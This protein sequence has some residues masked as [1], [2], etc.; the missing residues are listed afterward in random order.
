MSE[1]AGTSGP[2]PTSPDQS[3]APTT[4]VGSTSAT[5]TTSTSSAGDSSGG[6]PAWGSVLDIIPPALHDAVKG[7]LSEYDKN[8]N[9]R[10]EK[11]QSDY[12]P[13]KQFAGTDPGRMQEAL[14]IYQNLERDPQ[15]FYNL[16]AENLGIDVSGQGQTEPV[17]SD[18]DEI[19]LSDGDVDITEHPYVKQLAAQVEQLTNLF[20]GQQAQ[21]AQAKSD[22]WLEGR[23][24]NLPEGVDRDFV[25]THTINGINNQNMDPDKSMDAAIEKWNNLVGTIRSQP[26]AADSAPNVL[27]PSGG[28][29]VAPST[30]TMKMGGKEFRAAAAERLAQLNGANN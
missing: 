11:V 30:R 8:A 13:F 27:S 14:N 22:A 1:T 16:L 5:E 2:I 20:N 29:P 24:T 10:I 7:R 9:S 18:I 21:E 28:S 23:I 6:H 3:G 12:E 19:D 26:R 25:L 4:G 15:S 17:Q